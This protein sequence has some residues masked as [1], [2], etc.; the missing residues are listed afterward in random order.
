[1]VMG[2]VQI[3]ETKFENQD[4]K[5]KSSKLIVQRNGMHINKSVLS[6]RGGILISKNTS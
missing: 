5:I 6:S 2:Q 1:M 4:V 3:S